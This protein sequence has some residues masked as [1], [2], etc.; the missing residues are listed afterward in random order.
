MNPTP[1]HDLRRA[2]AEIEGSH[3]SLE[4]GG[5]LPLGLAEL[6]AALGGGFAF[7]AVHELAP[8]ALWHLGATTGFAL[9][10]A[11]RADAGS[12]NILWIQ[13]DFAGHEAGQLYGPGL[14]MFGLSLERLLVLRVARPTEALW[15]M[16]EALKC[17]ALVTVIAELT[18]EGAAADPTATRR[19]ALAARDGGVLGLLLRHRP[20]PEPSAAATRWEISAAPS[21]PD[22]F[23]GLG[24]T[25][26]TLSLSK[27]RRGSTG[28]WTVTWDHHER[29]FSPLSV[30]VAQTAADRP[31]RAPL[32]HSG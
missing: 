7:G 18:E 5:S 27:N 22:A 8:S 29:T 16:E 20:L 6:D 14:A 26:F 21:E 10:L 11:A 3:P 19:L 2:V 30:G 31:D 25:A 23:G 24:R 28:R 4:D 12:K 32:V 1:M 9:A 13:P 17:R 15:A